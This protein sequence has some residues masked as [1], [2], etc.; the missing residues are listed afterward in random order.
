MS[1]LVA[2]LGLLFLVFIH[3]LGH[4]SAAKG[5][6]MKALKFYVGFPPAVLKK[7]VGETE[8]GLGAIPLGG[9]VKI[10][11]M[12]RPE[13]DDLYAVE[14]VLERN[15]G[16]DT[17][18]A[19]SIATA[20]DVAR[21]DIKRA[22]WDD[23]RESLAGLT[24]AL[25][26][27]GDS[28]SAG[29]QKRCRRTVQ[30]IEESLD[31]R[32]YWRSARW[33]RLIAIAAGPAAN[34]IACFVILTGVAIFGRPEA[35]V[36]PR[37]HAVFKATPAAAS[38]LRAGDKLVSVNGS[39][40]TVDA[41]RNAIVASHGGVVH[42]VV[43]RDGKLVHLKPVHTKIIDGSYKMGFEFGEQI[44]S[45]SHPVLVAPRLAW[46]DMVR[47]T[48]GTIGAIGNVVTPQGRSQLHSAVGIVS[49]SAQEVHRGAGYY[50]TILA[51]VSLSLA[52]FNLLPFLPLDGGHIFLIVLERIRGRGVSRASF[53]RISIVGIALMLA[54]FAIG[55]QND[56]GQ[57]I[58]PGSH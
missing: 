21:S 41:M 56:L 46:D 7:Q 40:G 55:L 20:V 32:S 30:R 23:A 12:L 35:I 36:I 52:I 57:L 16:L 19:T 51:Y 45:R 8:Y 25:D 53:E 31:P 27:A 17:E 15:E 34:V 28:L 50:L 44:T 43:N 2:I 33:R 54:V 1:Y 26:A 39:S 13:P 24:A 22:R 14:D 9:Y 47:L 5:V 48:T 4:F 29:E 11:G 58:G 38:G 18:V 42:V 3:E 49:V 37:V 6:R 10:P